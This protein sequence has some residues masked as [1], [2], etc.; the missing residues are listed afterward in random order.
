MTSNT[1]SEK[2]EYEVDID[3]DYELDEEA[4]PSIPP[5]ETS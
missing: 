3:E 5:V 2:K 1:T 4:T